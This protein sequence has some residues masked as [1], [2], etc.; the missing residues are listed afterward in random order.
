MATELDWKP[1]WSALMIGLTMPTCEWSL[2]RRGSEPSPALHSS[3][4]ALHLLQVN[5]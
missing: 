3:R 2:S 1:L 4:V 5:R